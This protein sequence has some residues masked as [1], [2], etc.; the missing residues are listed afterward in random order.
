MCDHVKR[1]LRG[2][3]KRAS[4]PVGPPF[5]A[6]DTSIASSRRD[7]TIGTGLSSG[8][9]ADPEIWL[10]E[11]RDIRRRKPPI[12]MPNAGNGNVNSAIGDSIACL[13]NIEQTLPVKKIFVHPLVLLSVV[14]HFRRINRQYQDETRVMGVLLGSVRADKSVEIFNSFAAA[15]PHGGANGHPG[16]PEAINPGR[17]DLCR[18]DRYQS[19]SLAETKR[20]TY[21]T[22]GSE[23]LLENFCWVR[24]D[25]ASPI[26]L[27]GSDIEI[28]RKA[29]D[30]PAASAA[31][32]PRPRREPRPKSGI[33]GISGSH[34]FRWSPNSGLK[35]VPFDL[36]RRD[37]AIDV[38]HV[39]IRAATEDL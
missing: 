36:A 9:S 11:I 24:M 28:F 26:N 38:S 18:R 12:T 29:K 8:K 7:K 20:L 17:I 10:P 15:S 16:F 4:I 23:R 34:I 3:R 1:E 27:E 32:H 37:E 13:G 39:K 31:D 22:P 14:D 30:A 35:P 25:G 19:S 21:H 5:W 2:S 33:F 6:C